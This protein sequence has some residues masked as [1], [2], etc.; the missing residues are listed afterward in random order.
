MLPKRGTHI[1]SLVF[2]A[3]SLLETICR[4]F[5]NVESIRLPRSLTHVRSQRGS[6]KNAPQTC[7]HHETCWFSKFLHSKRTSVASVCKKWN[8]RFYIYFQC[9]F[10]PLETE[11]E[12]WKIYSDRCIF[13]AVI[14]SESFQKVMEHLNFQGHSTITPFSVFATH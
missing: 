13:L 1:F 3:L 11:R 6:V 9:F 12:R 14:P 8:P 5:Q 7:Q 10:I 2:T 4:G